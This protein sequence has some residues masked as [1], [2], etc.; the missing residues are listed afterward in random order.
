MSECFL[1]VML[2]CRTL[3]A[4]AMRSLH[5]LGFGFPMGNCG[6]PWGTVATRPSSVQ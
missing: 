6:Y 5:A 4:V 3:V 2:G 1:E